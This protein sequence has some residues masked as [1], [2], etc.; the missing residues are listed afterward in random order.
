VEDGITGFIA[1]APT[2]R[3]LRQAMDRAWERR[4]DWESIGK[5]AACAIREQIPAD[6]GAE[7]A[8]KLLALIETR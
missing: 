8:R 4:Y 3:H 2:A 1:E 5:A 7:F 6:P